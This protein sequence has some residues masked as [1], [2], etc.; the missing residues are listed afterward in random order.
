MQDKIDGN[1]GYVVAMVVLWLTVRKK[2]PSL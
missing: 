1:Y 2:N